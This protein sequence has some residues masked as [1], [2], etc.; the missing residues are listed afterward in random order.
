MVLGAASADT[1][2][3]F[4]ELGAV[5]LGLA[6]VARAAVALGIT[7]IPFYILVGLGLGRGGAV[8]LDLSED[9]IG[10]GA[11]IG[12]V[13]L[14]LALGLEYTPAELRSGLSRGWSAGV[15][16]LAANFPPGFL[17]GLLLGLNATEA[18]LLGGVT[19]ISSSGVIAK[20][21]DDLDRLGNRETPTILTVLVLEDLAM[22]AYL[23]LIAVLIA[24]DDIVSGSVTLLV[25][26]AVIA[27]ILVAALRLG[28]PLS[29]L[30]A[31]PSDE[32]VLL[33]VLG[34]TLLVAGA[35]QHLQVSSAVGAF[36]VGIA[37]SGPLQLRASAL[38]GPLRHLFAALFFLFF[39]LQI[40][41]ADLPPVLPVAI[42]LAVVTAITKAA[43]TW[44]ATARAGVAVPGR[45]RAASVLIIRG[46]FSI[47]IA[48]LGI[49]GGLDPELG[50][51]AAAYVLVLA[52]AGPLIARTVEP[53]IA[54]AR[55]TPEPA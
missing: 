52:I 11:E 9:F 31:S 37:L 22:G 55:R 5:V 54:R 4:V 28:D 48:G 30:L 18:V 1:A 47:V 3:V 45:I 23:P 49:A 16:D 20:L 46:E 10:L 41:P 33:S 40:D 13:L 14:L 44:W 42:V 53:A 43:S 2:L 19:Y 25:A 21:L 29:R 6:L 50:A 27:V 15:A 36:L 8:E 26:L 38:I 32:V 7:P 12:V 35:A 24:G 17:A 39:S 34:L 51:V